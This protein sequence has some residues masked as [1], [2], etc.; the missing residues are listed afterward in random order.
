[1]KEAALD[2]L[3]VV[4]ARRVRF[5]VDTTSRQMPATNQGLGIC[6]LQTSSGPPPNDWR[7]QAQSA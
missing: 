7:G 4:E 2:R 1:M 6:S 5:L 3:V